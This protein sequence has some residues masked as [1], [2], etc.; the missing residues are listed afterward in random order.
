[1]VFES[2]AK[3]LLKLV[4]AAV[5]MSLTVGCSNQKYSQCQSIIALANAANNQAQQVTETAPE[6]VVA[7][8][9]WLQASSIMSKAAQQIESLPTKDPQLIQYQ[10]NL[11]S[12]FRIYS[13]AIYEAVK[14]RENK[15]L[16]AL[17]VAR[18]N[19]QKAGELNQTLV[20]EINS[21][22]AQE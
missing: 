13:Q 17:K 21:Y 5:L 19:A 15:N 14:A 10:E 22:C 18:E 9:S 12:V 6:T 3:K 20:T 7:L 2:K 16:S 8:K 11:A 1:M 4:Y